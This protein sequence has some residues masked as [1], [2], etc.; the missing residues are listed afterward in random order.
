MLTVATVATAAASLALVV[1]FGFGRDGDPASTTWTLAIYAA[2][3]IAAGVLLSRPDVTRIGSAILL[4]TL[5]QGIVYRFQ[6][7]WQLEHPW[8]VATFGTCNAHHIWLCIVRARR[9][10]ALCNISIVCGARA[11]CHSIAELYG[12]SYVAGS[13]RMDRCHAAGD[14]CHFCRN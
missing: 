1:W 2:A 4:A 10:P 7:R 3:A 11:R 12:A 14:H 13:R 6:A 8:I 9:A 5:V